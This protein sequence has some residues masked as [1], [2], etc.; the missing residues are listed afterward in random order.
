MVAEVQIMH[1]LNHTNVLKFHDWYET[2]NNLWLILEYC[3]GGNLGQILKQDT[4]LPET[5]IKIFGLDIL[6]G[7]K[8]SWTCSYSNCSYYLH[9]FVTVFALNWNSTW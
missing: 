4:H 1:K 9:T 7:L 3:T 6:A 8:V 2:R 5:S